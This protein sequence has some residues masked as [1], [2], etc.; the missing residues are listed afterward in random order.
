M[1]FQ[2]FFDLDH[3]IVQDIKYREFVVAER[4]IFLKN[5]RIKFYLRL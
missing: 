3:L 2:Q 4:I 1:N 5:F